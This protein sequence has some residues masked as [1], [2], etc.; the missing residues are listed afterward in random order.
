[1]ENSKEIL[2]AIVKKMTNDGD[3]VKPDRN[4]EQVYVLIAEG[5]DGK[6]GLIGTNPPFM[7]SDPKMADMMLQVF[8]PT[9]LKKAEK[10]GVKVKMVKFG[11]KEVIKELS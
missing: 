8:T 7:F 5:S 6:E 4:I 3:S 9:I 1:M 10:E 11:T 2:E